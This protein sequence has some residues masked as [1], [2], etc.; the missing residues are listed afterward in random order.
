MTA[1]DKIFSAPKYAEKLMEII[2][3]R[4]ICVNFRHNLVEV[5]GK[6]REAVFENLDDN[7]KVTVKVSLSE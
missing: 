6:K 2:K 1:L 4:N 5:D 3:D 7:A